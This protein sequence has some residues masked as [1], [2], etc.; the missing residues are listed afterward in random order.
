MISHR[1]HTFFLFHE[2]RTTLR[3][4]NFPFHRP[5]TTNLCLHKITITNISG[6]FEI[7]SISDFP[8]QKSC[9]HSPHIVVPFFVSRKFEPSELGLFISYAIMIFLY[10]YRISAFVY[11]LLFCNRTACN[12]CKSTKKHLGLNH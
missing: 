2:K 3:S 10:F 1:N 9:L 8:G 7:C 4:N 12:L 11:L 6:K 5:Q